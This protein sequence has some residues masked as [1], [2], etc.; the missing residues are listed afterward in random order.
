MSNTRSSTGG[1]EYIMHVWMLGTYNSI[2]LLCSSLHN[3]PNLANYFLYP[4]S[5][6]AI[7]WWAATY[8]ER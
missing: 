6:V 8:M 5:V 7:A 4:Q 2:I 1:D 3:L